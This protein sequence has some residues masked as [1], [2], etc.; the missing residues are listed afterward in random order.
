MPRTAALLAAGAAAA[1]LAACGGDSA[2][3]QVRTV[4]TRFGTASAEKDY[5]QICDELIA[6][7]LSDNV[8]EFGLP[9]E[10]A[11]KQGLDPVRRP[12]LTI[13]SVE[14]DGDRARVAVHSTAANQPPSDD[15][16]ELRRTEGD[17][18]ITALAR[19]GAEGAKP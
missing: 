7:S 3:D 19:S 4:V 12:K 14:V 2:E 16:L 15:T 17:W 9:C 11:F 18:K 13:R 6:K 5:Q 1:L 10:L 8:E